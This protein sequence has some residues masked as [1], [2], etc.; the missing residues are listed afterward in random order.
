ML[1]R[2]GGKDMVST[3]QAEF[4]DSFFPGGTHIGVQGA[5]WFAKMFSELTKR[6]VEALS[7]DFEGGWSHFLPEGLEAL[8]YYDLYVR[9]IPFLDDGSGGMLGAET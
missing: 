8:D 5:S 6:R 4:P 9:P 3:L 2:Y 1:S 7:V